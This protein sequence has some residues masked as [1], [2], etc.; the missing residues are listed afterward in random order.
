MGKVFKVV[1]SVVKGV[2]SVVSGVGNLLGGM[3]APKVQ[4]PNV[5]TALTALTGMDAAKDIAA[6]E[7]TAAQEAARRSEEERRRRALFGRASTFTG[8]QSGLIGRAIIGKKT[9]LGQ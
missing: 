4:M 2:G 5:P 6:A 8:G 9:L 7:A 1:K 3:E